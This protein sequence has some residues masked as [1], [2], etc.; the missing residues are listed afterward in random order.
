MTNWALGRSQGPYQPLSQH[1]HP[2]SVS[3]SCG[4]LKVT[5]RCSKSGQK[6]TVPLTVLVMRW[7]ESLLSLLP[8][9]RPTLPRLNRRDF[10]PNIDPLLSARLSRWRPCWESVK[11][12]SCLLE[13][14][15]WAV[16]HGAGDTL[17][18]WDHRP[19]L[20]P[21][22]AHDLRGSS[23]SELWPVMTQ[24]LPDCGRASHVDDLRAG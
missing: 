22:D 1:V 6:K 12:I 3:G 21:F 20:I 7:H 9:N 24:V 4:E 14:R 2:T 23:D 11:G 16:R 17:L 13:C 5:L 15:A 18:W 10:C 8:W 19:S